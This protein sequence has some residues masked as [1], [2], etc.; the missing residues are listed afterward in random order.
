MNLEEL[1]KEQLIRLVQ[2]LQKKQAQPQDQPDE[3]KPTLGER[4]MAWLAKNG[5]KK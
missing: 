3:Y 5:I 4:R 1:S 2:T